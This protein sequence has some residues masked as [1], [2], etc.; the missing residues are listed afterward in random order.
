MSVNLAHVISVARQMGSSDV[1]IS[2]GLPVV[3]RINGQLQPAPFE[4]TSAEGEAII[5]HP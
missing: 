2:V 1:H 3:Y 4:V 5:H